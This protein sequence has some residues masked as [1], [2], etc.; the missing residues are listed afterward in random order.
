[1]TRR[2]DRTLRLSTIADRIDRVIDL[3]GQG[4]SWLVGVTVVTCALV[5]LLRYAFGLGW[6]WM[7]DAYVWANATMFMLAAAPT[8]LHGKHVRVDFFYTNAR[9]RMRAAINLFGVLFLLLP[10]V[11][12]IFLLCLPY[13]QDSLS[14]LEG[15]L[16]VGG[17]PGVFL[18]K[19]VLLLFCIPLAAQGLSL[20]I[21]SWISLFGADRDT[22]ALS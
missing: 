12:T 6:V 1:M 9:P 7:Q 4:L 8:L 17:L 10:S 16:D 13:V 5:A 2:H 15:A 21:R 20:A 22:G 18:L 19:A 3:L 14:R 11:V